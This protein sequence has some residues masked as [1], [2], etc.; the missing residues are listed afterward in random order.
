MNNHQSF[1]VIC[2]FIGGFWLKIH[3]N[4]GMQRKKVSYIVP[5]RYIF[6]IV[7]V[8][9]S[10]LNNKLKYIMKNY[11]LLLPVF[12][13]CTAFAQ[14]P[15]VDFAFN[16]YKKY[17]SFGVAQA[18]NEKAEAIKKLRNYF[19]EHPYR[20]KALKDGVKAKE[21]L[22]L[23]TEK[24]TFSDMDPIE[25]GFD[26]NDT[27]NKGYANTS[28]D[29][30][31]IF[32]GDA[33]E[34]IFQICSACRLGYISA[35]EALSDNLMKAIK[36]YGM[37]EISRRND[38][39]RFHA[40][41]FAIPT[42]AVNVYFAMLDLM[43]KAERGEASS[44]VTEACDMLKVVGLQAWTQPLRKDATDDNVVSIERFR[45]HVWWVGGNALA[46]RSLLPVAAM[47]SSVPMVDLLAEVCRRGISMTSQVTY[48]DSF[49]TEG[50]TADGAGWGHGKQCLVWGYP[51]DGASNA[52][53]MLTML[54]GTPWAQQLDK[55]NTEAL[56]NFFR[57]G[58]WYYYKGYRL[59]GLDR[60][61]YV[62]NP[63]EKSIPYAKMLDGVVKN[64]ISS[65]TPEEQKE[66]LALQKEVKTNRIFMDG[67]SDGM[68]KGMRWFFNNDDLMKKTPDYHIDINMASFRTDGLESAAF[69]DN[70]NFYPTDGA[71][72]FQ[73]SG[74]EYFKVMGGWDVTAMPGVTAREGMDRLVP[75][76]NWRGYCSKHNFAAGAT[77]GHEDGVA[78]I[79][80]EKM[81]GSDKEGV[82]D[83]GNAAKEENEML[84]GFKVYKGYFIMGD[85]F[86]ALGAGFTNMQ[87][88]IEGDLR[89]TIDQT[90]WVDDV[91]T[92]K[93][94]NK[95]LVKKG[96]IIAWKSDKKNPVWISQ[97]GKFSYTV[98]PQFTKEA[99]VSCE[100]KPTDWEKRN[101]SNK[102]L[103]SK[104]SE[105]NI[106][107]IWTEHGRKPVNDTYGYVVYAGTDV[108]K[109]KLPFEV[110][111][112][113]T[114]VQAVRLLDKTVVQAVFYPGNKGLK[115][116]GFSMSVSAPAAVMVKKTDGKYE[117][118]VTEATMNPDIKELVV[119][120]NGKEY[121]I[122]LQQGIR[123]GS[124]VTAEF[125]I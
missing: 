47:Y 118:S 93:K 99:Y 13:G 68:Y 98:L 95:T 15:E 84:Y 107:R 49:W 24:G 42:A 27:Y 52:L 121:K 62:Y 66:L 112:N 75:V 10:Q 8:S 104:P 26:E 91:Y 89:T 80:F 23:L 103:S 97:K 19:S 25:R 43:D 92:I 5:F 64:W 76:T 57:G 54:R 124:S 72:L 116:K 96:E 34:R 29:A 122:A 1:Y 17:Y 78:G 85:Y 32:I 83:K 36:H 37:L 59:P 94:G 58:S 81:N 28:D 119:T 79:I 120:I 65:F 73:R 40:S 41:C 70:Y 4:N 74:D 46:Y 48:E 50:F 77:D 35:D 101:L 105:V 20:L 16:N 111:S 102:K 18:D 100:T 22:S 45:N 53:N 31:G 106:L 7:F 56:M 67:Y 69:A 33:F 11:L 86:V 30:A 63:D 125:E 6:I 9:L 55:S 82:N 60:G 87:P 123:C 38:R 12:W 61:S 113:D 14:Q 115:Y 110:M 109:G 3:V 21:Y 90:A 2:R 108:P 88:E 114:L 39:P 44:L 117:I 51:I 71:T